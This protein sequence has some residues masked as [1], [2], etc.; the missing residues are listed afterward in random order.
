MTIWQA[1]GLVYLVSVVI[2]II[3]KQCLQDY[4]RENLKK[5]DK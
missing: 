1:R 3:A 5:K 4:I 2:L